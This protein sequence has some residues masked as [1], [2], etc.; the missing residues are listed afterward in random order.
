MIGYMFIMLSTS[1]LFCTR[2]SFL[3][4]GLLNT[5]FKFRK[6]ISV[7]PLFMGGF[8]SKM[9]EKEEVITSNSYHFYVLILAIRFCC[10]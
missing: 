7:M 2:T 4:E 1:L 6:V 5:S 3:V 9:I 10:I 8:G